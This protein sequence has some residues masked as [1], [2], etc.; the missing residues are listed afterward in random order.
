VKCLALGRGENAPVSLF[1]IDGARR[2]E[3]KRNVA[4]A[5]LNDRLR[6]RFGR[7]AGFHDSGLKASRILSSCPRMRNSAR[8]LLT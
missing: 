2:I 1:K 4:S 3:S 7:K 5:A 6:W 8:Q